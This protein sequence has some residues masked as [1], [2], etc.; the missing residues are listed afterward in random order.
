VF[1]TDAEAHGAVRGPELVNRF[2][3][4]KLP[5]FRRGHKRRD[6]HPGLQPQFAESLFE[7]NH[8]ARLV[9]E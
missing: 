5:E 8:A 9:I 6:R 3:G 2:P 4:K 7:G 1:P